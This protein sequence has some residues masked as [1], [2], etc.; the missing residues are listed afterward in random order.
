MFA[1]LYTIIYL[2]CSQ[3]IYTDPISELLSQTDGQ[4]VQWTRSLPGIGRW[5]MLISMPR[6]TNLFFGR[7]VKLSLLQT[8]RALE[9]N[10]TLS[11]S[12]S[13]T[14]NLVQSKRKVDS[15][16]IYHL[17]LLLVGSGQFPLWDVSE[18]IMVFFV[19]WSGLDI[20]L[21]NTTTISSNVS[22]GENRPLNAMRKFI[23]RWPWC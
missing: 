1:R 22:R 17:V 4:N 21:M 11:F 12:N 5:D 18:G 16:F 10:I 23:T 3:V 2:S 13:L 7:L 8:E 19:H 6:F 20:L 15:E 9:L 14:R